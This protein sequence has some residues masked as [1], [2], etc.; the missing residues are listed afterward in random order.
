MEYLSWSFNSFFGEALAQTLCRGAEVKFEKLFGSY[1]S[2][3]ITFEWSGYT[4]RAIM[5]RIDF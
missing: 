1:L 5:C 4:A 3:L 2:E